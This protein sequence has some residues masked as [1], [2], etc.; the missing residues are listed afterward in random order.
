MFDDSF[1]TV[2]F[3]GIFDYTFTSVDAHLPIESFAYVSL[4]QFILK[5]LAISRQR[6]MTTI[7]K[8]MYISHWQQNETSSGNPQAI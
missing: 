1:T 3:I 6:A 4:I 2:N 5:P 8:H 7:V